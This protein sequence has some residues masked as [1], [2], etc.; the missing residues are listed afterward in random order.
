MRELI[1]DDQKKKA[2]EKLESLLLEGLE[3]PSSPMTKGDWAE[4]HK[5]LKSRRQSRV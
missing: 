5:N 3:G 1:R 2:K 4:L